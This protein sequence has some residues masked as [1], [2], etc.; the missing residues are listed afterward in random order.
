MM[1]AVTESDATAADA[2]AGAERP[3][4]S[5]RRPAI[6]VVDD[7]PTVL[8]AVSRDLRRGFGERFRVLRAGSGPQALE[9]LREL[10]VRGDQVAMLIADQRMPG[11]PGTE[12]LA[13]ARKIAP[14]AKRVLLTAYADTEAAIAAINE[15]AL[16]YYLLKPWDPPEEQLFPVVEDLLTTWEAGAALEAG[17]VRL[18]GHRYSKESHDLRDFLVR[19]R[20]PARWLD[21]ERDGEARELLQVAGV[22]PERLPVALL[23]DG[24][25]LE[26]P[27]ILEL[28]ERLGVVGAPAQSH[29]D[30]VVVGGGPAGLA[31]AVYGASEGLKTVLVEREAPGGQAGQSSRIENYLGFPAGLSGSDLARRATD[32]ARRLGAELLTVHEAIALR[33]EGAA[34]IVELSGAETL[35]A[36]CVIVASGVSYRQL[37]TPG[38]AELTGAGVYYGA[39]MTE[40]RACERQQVVVIGGANSAGQAA[41]YFSGYAA[42]VTMLVRGASLEQSMSHYLIEQIAALPNIEVRTA[43]SAI[44][45]EGEDGH[46]RRLQVQGPDGEQ[47]LEADACFVFIGASPRTDWLDGV[48]ARDARGFILAGRDAQNNGWP[49]Q[50][51]PY[52]LEST[53]PGVFVAGDVRSRSIK[54]VASA[55][56]EGSMAVSLVHEYL[57]DA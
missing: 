9:L 2:D 20:V 27:T 16:D 26:R 31:A 11:M 44:A 14:D 51:E 35:S 33:T 50:R 22:D 25:V 3:H 38:F 17:G 53:V 7:E 47:T 21:I 13:Q 1:P 45:A 29:Y 48:V 42:K 34:R 41:V 4:A 43:S 12:Y 56:G 10:G 49:L 32:Q 36:S 8:A 39:A 15:V 40:A 19:N 57:L 30:L 28:A 24:A 6:L 55:V 46:L 18:I 37:D 52:L 23:E 5:E 54:R